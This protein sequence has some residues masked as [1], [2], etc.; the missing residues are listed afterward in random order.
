MHQWQRREQFRRAQRAADAVTHVRQ[1]GAIQ[2]E[3]RR[4]RPPGEDRVEHRRGAVSRQPRGQRGGQQ[5]RQRARLARECPGREHGE[6][7]GERAQRRPPQQ[8]KPQA[9]RRADAGAAKPLLLRGQP[10]AQLGRVEQ[11]ETTAVVP[12]GREQR[13]LSSGRGSMISEI[14]PRRVG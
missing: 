11:R 3:G 14:Q 2:H 8:P 7:D 12:V 1:G 5:V 9:A 4:W 10:L 13:P 6:G